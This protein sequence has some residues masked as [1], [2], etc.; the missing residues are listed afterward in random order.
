MNK[1][2]TFRFLI[3]GLV[4]GLLANALFSLPSFAEEDEPFDVNDLYNAELSLDQHIELYHEQMNLIFNQTIAQLIPFLSA[5]KDLANE[6]IRKKV[7]ERITVPE[8]LPDEEVLNFCLN[9]GENMNLS[10]YCLALRADDLY[11]NYRAA[12][13]FRREDLSGS[14]QVDGLSPTQTQTETFDNIY[15]QSRRIDRELVDAKKAFEASITVYQELQT[16]FPLHM[17]FED[18]KDA[19]IK[20]RDRLVE[21]RK[22][23]DEFPHRFTNSTSDACK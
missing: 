5:N 13:S 6:E 7:L 20:Y 15:D 11:E 8:D 21:I 1:S 9:R 10:T 12:L 18:M 23:V 4:M 14:A 17:Q 22:K 3:F 16:A 2:A 19:L